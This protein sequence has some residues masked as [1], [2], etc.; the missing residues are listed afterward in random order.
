MPVPFVFDL[1]AAMAAPVEGMNQ[2][3]LS[4]NQ[5]EATR[6]LSAEGSFFIDRDKATRGTE[7]HRGFGT[8]GTDD[9]RDRRFDQEPEERSITKSTAP[10]SIL[11]QIKGMS[12]S[13]PENELREIEE[14]KK[15]DD[16][17]EM[18]G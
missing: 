5:L 2:C 6:P 8:V 3:V 1:D 13:I 9:L 15:D 4:L 16:S 14:G 18:G 11:G 17:P 10:S 12:N 7:T